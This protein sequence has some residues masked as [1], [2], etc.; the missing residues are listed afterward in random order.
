MKETLEKLYNTR[1][2]NNCPECYDVN[3]LELTIYQREKENALYSQASPNIE[4]EL[5]CNTCNTRIYPV[6]WDLD[7]ERIVDYHS[8]RVKTK[9]ST[10]RLKKL[11]YFLIATDIILLI[12]LVYYLS[13]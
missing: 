6:N 8:K 12:L 9:P 3:G 7:I 4:T 5:H 13:T 11:A 10:I 1:L 2:N